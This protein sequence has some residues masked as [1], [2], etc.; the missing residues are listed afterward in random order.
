MICREMAPHVHRTDLIAF[1]SDGYQCRALAFGGFWNRFLLML[2]VGGSA[3]RLGLFRAPATLL[4]DRP[5]LT[6]A[7]VWHCMP[8]CP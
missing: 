1:G 4:R 2:A 6:A 3:R 5:S 8:K 7:S